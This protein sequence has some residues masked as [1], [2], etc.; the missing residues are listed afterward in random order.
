MRQE[1]TI[2]TISCALL[3]SLPCG[4]IAYFSGND[5]VMD[6]VQSLSMPRELLVYLFV[7]FIFHLINVLA[8]SKIKFQPVKGTLNYRISNVIDLVGPSVVGV[9]R[10][11]AGI[12]LVLSPVAMITDANPQ[13]YAYGVL[14]LSF[15]SI[16]I[17][18]SS[19]IQVVTSESRL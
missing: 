2:E 14:G 16:I 5:A 18:S 19:W 4:L 12:L 17:L 15:A 10:V 9:Y 1:I 8:R 3:G 13:A 7:L 6:Y 11:I